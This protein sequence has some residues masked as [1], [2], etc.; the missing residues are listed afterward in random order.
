MLFTELQLSRRSQLKFPQAERIQ[1]VKKSMGAIRHV[2]GERKREKLAQF[3]LRGVEQE[4][5]EKGTEED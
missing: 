4:E 2:L 1:K 3:A 5:A